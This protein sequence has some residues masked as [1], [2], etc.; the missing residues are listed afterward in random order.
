MARVKI[1]LNKNETELDADHA[2]QKA[3]EIHTSGAVHDEQIFSDPAMAHVAQRMNE[4][5]DRM[6]GEMVREIQDVLD[7]EY[8]HGG[9]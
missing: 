2:V 5:H 8:S 1:F 9:E 4:I 3:M 7:E 6:Y